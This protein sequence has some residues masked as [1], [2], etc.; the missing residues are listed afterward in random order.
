MSHADCE[1]GF[2]SLLLEA[3]PGVNQ[4]LIRQTIIMTLCCKIKHIIHHLAAQF[5]DKTT[6]TKVFSVCN[7]QKF[8]SIRHGVV[9]LMH[10]ESIKIYPYID[11]QGTIPKN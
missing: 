4:S 10:D 9:F 1:S 11:A 3:I 5:V 6:K 2:E 7:L 8:N